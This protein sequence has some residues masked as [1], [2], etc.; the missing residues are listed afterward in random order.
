MAKPDKITVIGGGGGVPPEPNWTLTFADELDQ[1]LAS[2]AWTAVISEMRQAEIL[3]VANGHAIKRLVEFRIHYEHAAR[4]VAEN[5][6][7]LKRVRAKTGQWNPWWSVMRQADE[8]IR[9]LEA[10]LGIS[11]VRRAKAGKVARPGPKRW[12]PA[13]EF[14]G[15]TPR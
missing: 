4:H 11:P 8:K 3:S 2:G 7:V 10:E 12:S 13:D 15:E 14:L 9:A 1:V 5:G 6:P